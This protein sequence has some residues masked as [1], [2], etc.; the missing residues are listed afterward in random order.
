MFVAF[1]TVVTFALSAA[2]TTMFIFDISSQ[3]C[4]N[5]FLLDSRRV[6]VSANKSATQ[7][8]PP[9]LLEAEALKLEE[10]DS[11]DGVRRIQESFMQCL[12]LKLILIYVYDVV[13]AVPF[14][15]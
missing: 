6:G 13:N 3:E 10:S 1:L 4:T 15:F 2:A 14:H 12:S 9:R 8:T 7:S 11:K 5:L